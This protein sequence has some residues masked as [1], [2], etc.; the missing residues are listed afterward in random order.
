MHKDKESKTETLRKAKFISHTHTY[1]CPVNKYHNQAKYPQSLTTE[2]NKN[3][4]NQNLL[5]N[6]AYPT[7]QCLLESRRRG[8]ESLLAQ[9]ALE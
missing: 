8:A 1:M 9:L 4:L 7:K 6:L 2:K 3:I 5:S